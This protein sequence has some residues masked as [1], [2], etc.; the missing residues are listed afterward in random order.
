MK[1]EGYERTHIGMHLLDSFDKLYFYV[2]FC[3]VCSV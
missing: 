2:V 1:Y 3:R